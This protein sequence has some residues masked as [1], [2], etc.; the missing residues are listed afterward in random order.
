MLQCTMEGVLAIAKITSVGSVWNSISVICNMGALTLYVS[1][2]DYLYKQF[3]VS[4]VHVTGVINGYLIEGARVL[5]RSKNGSKRG[6]NGLKWVKKG[7]FR[8]W[9]VKKGGSEHFFINLM[10]PV[11]PP[12]CPPKL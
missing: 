2:I 3:T 8:L 1:F 6:Q 5:K 9:R 12:S 10:V 7:C 4:V 11:T